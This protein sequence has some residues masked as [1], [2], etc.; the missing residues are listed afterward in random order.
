MAEVKKNNKTKAKKSSKVLD[1]TNKLTNDELLEQ[2]LNKKKNKVSKSDTTNKTVTKASSAKKVSS[3]KP[4]KKVEK[5][6]E[7][8]SD[9]IYEKIRAKRTIKKRPVPKKNVDKKDVINSEAEVQKEEIT[10]EKETIKEQEDLIITREIRF[11]DLSSNLKD[12]KTLQELKEAIENFDKIDNIE[13]N[14]DDKLNE[15]FELLPFIKY[16]NYKLKRNLVIVGVIILIVITVFGIVFGVSTAIDSIE[17]AKLVAAEKKRVLEE[18][19]KKE[20]EERR[21][22]KLYEECLERPY[23]DSD[24]TEEINSAMLQLNNYFKENYSMSV[25]YEDL[26][27]GFTYVYRED[28]IY[29]AAS[30]IKS[31]EALY[32]YTKAREGVI[33]LDDTITYTK[34]FKVSYSTGVSKHKIGDK[35]PIRDLVKYSVVYSDNSAHQML[36]SYIGKSTLKK[37]GN[38]LGA[39][40]TLVGGDNFGNISALDGAIYMK[41]LNEFFQKNDEYA[42]EL[43]SFFFEA[44]QKELA[45]NNLKVANKYGLYKK[46]YHNIGIMYDER[47]YIIS[48]LTLEGLKNKEEKISDISNK[49]YELHLLYKTNR[50]N[51]CKLEIYSE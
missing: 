42:K 16:A 25:V 18:Q 22:K 41:A 47:P 4:K 50:E 14:N 48:I 35:I 32:V 9:D 10:K 40:N 39:V 28:V 8:S 6:E 20:A 15:D 12:K 5:K 30:T 38:D 29:Y 43:K 34:K 11:D 37:F 36:I 24:N 51:V 7:V 1:E 3:T 21:K 44:E 19:K 33:D 2:I 49:I 46:Y 27:Y 23:S 31:L 45:V 26:T 17:Q 13:N